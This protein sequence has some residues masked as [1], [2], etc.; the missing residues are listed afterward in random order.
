MPKESALI[1]WGTRAS[2]YSSRRFQEGFK[3]VS[4]RYNCR[5]ATV[6]GIASKKG[7]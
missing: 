4:R 1:E 3:K 7:E 6:T 5:I 2:R